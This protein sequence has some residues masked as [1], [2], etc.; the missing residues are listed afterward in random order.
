MINIMEIVGAY[1]VASLLFLGLG[2]LVRRWFFE[3]SQIQTSCL[4]AGW[5]LSIALLQVWHIFM[6]VDWR[7]FLML[8]MLSS[9][10]LLRALPE[11]RLAVKGHKVFAVACGAVFLALACWVALHSATQPRNMDSGLYHLN[12]VRWFKEYAVVPGLG[13]LHARLAFNQN[14]FLYVASLDVGIFAHKSHQ[15]ASGLLMLWIL[16]RGIASGYRMISGISADASCVY[17]VIMLLPVIVQIVAGDD[18][19]SPS[20]DVGAYM[21]GVVIGSE[22]L[23]WLERDASDGSSNTGVMSLRRL[24]LFTVVGVTVKLSM[25]G[26]AIGVMCVVYIDLWKFNRLDEYKGQIVKVALFLVCIIILPWI[27]RGIIQSGY[28]AYPSTFG[29]VA[30]PWRLPE[31]EVTHIVQ[32]VKT[33]SRTGQYEN[34][35]VPWTAWLWPWFMRMLRVKSFDFV[36]PLA[37]SALC[38]CLAI[39]DGRHRG[40]GLGNFP[41]HYLWLPAVGIVFWFFTAPDP[42]FAGA[43]LWMLPA[44]L[45]CW[46]FQ[47]TRTRC[48]I[49]SLTFLFCATL[50]HQA[51]IPDLITAWKRD[52]GVAKSIPMKE[53]TTL[54]GLKILVPGDG[55]SRPWDSALP[56]AP[57]LRPGLRLRNPPSLQDGFVLD[58]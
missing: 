26:I 11:I 19:C 38:F 3:S 54:S 5:C 37:L 27:A 39:L 47:G 14:F 46:A 40:R 8:V 9:A 57:E 24:M 18:I 16:M 49:P 56:A 10:G 25:L 31:Q 55:G 12:T 21:L 41:L 20:P 35:N 4:W 45:I 22:V 15:L 23:R 34:L 42:R 52:P 30:V 58:Q 28:I 32:L 29:G 2:L 43:V 13:N 48:L 53:V 36:L 50:V 51:S 7:A 44:G 33:W 17:D 6:P 1:S